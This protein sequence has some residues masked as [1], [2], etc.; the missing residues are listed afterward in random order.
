MHATIGRYEGV[1][2]SRTNE[3]TKRADENAALPPV[4][5]KRAS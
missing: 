2:A 1:D 4:P 5:A 3:F